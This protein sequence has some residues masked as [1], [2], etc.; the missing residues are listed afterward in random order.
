MDIEEVAKRIA[1]GTSSIRFDA[2]RNEYILKD[3]YN[4]EIILEPITYKNLCNCL[5]KKRWV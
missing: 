1:L 5:S 2:L 4:N 3:Y